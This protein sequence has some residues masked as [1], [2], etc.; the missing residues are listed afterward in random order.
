MELGDIKYRALIG[1]NKTWKKHVLYS[2]D[3]DSLSQFF[4]AVES[5]K[6][7]GIEVRMM[8]GTG[9]KDKDGVEVYEGDRL[10]FTA[11]INGVERESQRSIV[12]RWNDLKACF[13]G[14]ES[15]DKRKVVV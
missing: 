3:Y 1:G 9:R 13:N 8:R 7:Q 4:S 2:K 5:F 14:L 10:R 6:D 11:I 12:V 15:L